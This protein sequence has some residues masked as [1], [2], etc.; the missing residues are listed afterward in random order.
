MEKEPPLFLN[1]TEAAELLRCSV[2]TINNLIKAEKLTPYR[3]NRLIIFDR[4]E[5][6][7]AVM[8]KDLKN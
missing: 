3:F 6:I 5:I 2:G 4:Q 7:D 1:K 8:K